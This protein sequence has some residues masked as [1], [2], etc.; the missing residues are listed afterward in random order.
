MDEALHLKHHPQPK[1]EEDAED[2]E[3]VLGGEAL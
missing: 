1:T 3:P 2:G